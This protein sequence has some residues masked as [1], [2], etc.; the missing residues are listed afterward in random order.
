MNY[1]IVKARIETQKPFK[2]PSCSGVL[3]GDFYTV[4]SYRTIIYTVNMKTGEHTLNTNW[5]SVTTR[6]LQRMIQGIIGRS[7]G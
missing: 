7:E 2:H 5:F 3:A 4:Y 1:K 6:K